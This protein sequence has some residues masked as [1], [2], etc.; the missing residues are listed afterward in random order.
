MFLNKTYNST[1]SLNEEFIIVIV[2]F[3]ENVFFHQNLTSFLLKLSAECSVAE[4]EPPGAA[5]FRAVPEPEP[6]FFGRSRSRSRIFRAAPAAS[7]RHAKKKS[8]VLVLVYGAGAAFF[9]LEPEPTQVDRS[10]SRL[11][12]LGHL[13]PEP[14][15]KVAAPQ[16]WCCGSETIYYRTIQ[17]NKKLCFN[18]RKLVH[19]YWYNDTTPH[20]YWYLEPKTLKEGGS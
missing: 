18:F 20:K 4:P 2:I 1:T 6:I 17:V 8:L 3:V 12:D 19:I 14:L 9:C 15:K 5:T 7:F 16:H 10:R 13:E 11:R